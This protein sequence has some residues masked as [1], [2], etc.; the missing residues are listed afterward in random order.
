M[1]NQSGNDGRSRENADPDHV[2]D[3]QRHTVACAQPPEKECLCTCALNCGAGA[4]AWCWTQFVN[5]VI[6]QGEMLQLLCVFRK[7]LSAD[8][9]T[10]GECNHNR[11]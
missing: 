8:E 1:W 5:R 7:S 9:P 3:D 2:R 10:R 4:V 6:H 11:L